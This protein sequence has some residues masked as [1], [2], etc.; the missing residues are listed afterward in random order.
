MKS[1]NFGVKYS[2]NGILTDELN[3]MCS[4]LFMEKIYSMELSWSTL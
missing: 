3:L 4:L 1:L 2:E